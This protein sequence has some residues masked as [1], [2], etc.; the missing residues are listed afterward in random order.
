VQ[1]DRDRVG[2]VDRDPS[3]PVP[4]P[5]AHQAGPPLGSTFLLRELLGLVGLA[6][7]GCHRVQDPPTQVPQLPGTELGRP[8]D[9][10]RFGITDHLGWEGVCRQLVQRVADHLGLRHVHLAQSQGGRYL[11]PPLLQRLSQGQL[12]PVRP[13]V[14][15]GLMGQQRRDVPGPLI[16]RDIVGARHQ[17]QLQRR[18]QPVHAVEH[19]VHPIERRHHAPPAPTRTKGFWVSHVDAAGL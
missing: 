2:H 9:Q 12:A 19:R 13:V 10:V 11:G 8:G 7:L 3:R 4:E 1:P 16:Q 17:P 18:T 5:L 15:A 6:D 14:G